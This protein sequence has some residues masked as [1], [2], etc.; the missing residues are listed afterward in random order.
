VLYL[1]S[2][3]L[4]KHYLAERGTQA[5]NARLDEEQKSLRSPFTSVLTYAEVHAALARLKKEGKL[6]PDQ[7]V[8]VQ[9][10]FDSDW[11]LTIS[12][13]DCGAGILGFVRNVVAEA[14]LRGADAVHLAS[15]LWLRDMARLGVRQGHYTGALVFASSDLQLLKAAHK[16]RIEVFNP[17]K[18]K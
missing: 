1:D 9:D 7:T 10:K 12:P 13:I 14:P 6:T 18:T 3:A 17:E 16:H 5:L 4:I 11:V 8:G 15:A 2:S